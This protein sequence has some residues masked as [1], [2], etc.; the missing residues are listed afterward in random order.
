[1]WL[2]GD[3]PDS[4]YDSRDFGPLPYSLIQSRVFFRV[5]RGVNIY[6]FKYC[7]PSLVYAYISL[8]VNLVRLTIGFDS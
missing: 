3:N 6:M 7:E 4:S 5:S 2:E 1:M 8:Q